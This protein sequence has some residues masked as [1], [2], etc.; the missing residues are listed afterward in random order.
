MIHFTAVSKIAI[1][2]VTQIAGA[3]A[4]LADNVGNVLLHSIVDNFYVQQITIS[5]Q[6][7]GNEIIFACNE[8]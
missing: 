6:E 8:I 5:E 4:K 1:N 3:F 7:F 2:V